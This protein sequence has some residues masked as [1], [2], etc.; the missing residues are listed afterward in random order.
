MRTGRAPAR[1]AP[2]SPNLSAPCAP[3]ARSQPVRLSQYNSLYCNTKSSATSC[4][5]SQYT[6]VYCDTLFSPTRL[7]YRK[8]IATQSLP[9]CSHALSSLQYN[10]CIAI[11]PLP[12]K[13]L[14][15]NTIWAV[16][17]IRFYTKNIF[18][19]SLYYLFFYIISSNWKTPKKY[20]HVYIYIYIY[21]FPEHQINLKFYFL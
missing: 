19:F 4:L 6:N 3:P 9:P 1:P 12:F 2:R 16:A 15:H 21:I 10:T 7:Q 8:C 11:Q 14:S 5:L 17:Q 13:P 20:I 18:R